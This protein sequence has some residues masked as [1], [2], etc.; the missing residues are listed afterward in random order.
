M[1]YLWVWTS[2]SGNKLSEESW[3]NCK[4]LL[5]SYNIEVDG[6]IVSPIA[7]EVEGVTSYLFNPKD[8]ENFAIEYLLKN[9]EMTQYDAMLYTD[10]V[11]MNNIDA[12]RAMIDNLN[13]GKNIVHVKKVHSKI[14]EIMSQGLLKVKNAINKMI[15]GTNQNTYLHNF[16][17]VDKTVIEMLCDFPNRCGFILETN[18]LVNTDIGVVEVG[19]KIAKA[20]TKITNP[21]SYLFVAIEAL[22]AISAFVLAIWLPL[23]LGQ[24]LWL[25]ILMICA[26]VACVMHFSIANIDRVVKVSKLKQEPTIIKTTETK[27]IVEEKQVELV[28]LKGNDQ[29]D[30]PTP[31]AMKSEK[32]KLNKKASSTTNKASTIKKSSGGTTSKKIDS[33]KKVNSTNKT[34]TTNKTKP[35]KKTTTQSKDTKTA[36]TKKS[37]GSK[38]SGNT[39]KPSLSTRETKDKSPNKSKT[40]TNKTKSTSKGD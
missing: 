22:V 39:K 28:L 23:N 4:D 9:K 24:I 29:V 30:N 1:K 31:I 16:V 40:S 12:F 34:N 18:Y 20:K 7:Y 36:T 3:A 33:S 11:Y 19:S 10:A 13:E 14:V 26:G 17:A 5:K 32:E 27:E 38:K 2:F 21:I 35:A 25:I 6:V 15:L 8:N 37:T